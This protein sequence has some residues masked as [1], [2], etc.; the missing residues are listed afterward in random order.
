[1]PPRKR[2]EPE[3]IDLTGDDNSYVHQAKYRR[4]NAPSQWHG[5]G[6]APSSQPSSSY[7]RQPSSSYSRQP[8]S[9]YSQ[10]PSSQRS[11]I[12]SYEEEPEQI[13]LTQTDDGPVRELYGSLGMKL[14]L[15][16]LP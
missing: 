5:Y 13:D 12:V 14:A 8:S 11:L 9:S 15:M 6:S 10:Q 4:P 2:K 1:M 3:T 16:S 7:A